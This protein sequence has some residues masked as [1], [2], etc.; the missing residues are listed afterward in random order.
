MT[1]M[2]VVIICLLNHYK[3][4]TWSFIARQSQA[5][6]H[7]HALQQVGHMHKHTHTPTYAQK[8]AFENGQMESAGQSRHTEDDSAE[9]QQSQSEKCV[10]CF[11]CL[12][13]MSVA[14]RQQLAARSLRGK[15]SS[16]SVYRRWPPEEA[17]LWRSRTLVLLDPLL[18]K[19]SCFHVWCNLKVKTRPFPEDSASLSVFLYSFT[20]VCVYFR[21]CTDFKLGRGDRLHPK[22]E[23]WSSFIP[24]SPWHLHNPTHLWQELLIK[25]GLSSRRRRVENLNISIHNKCKHWCV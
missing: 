3:F 19:P 17:P 12:E 13:R 1:V 22:L 16:W 18:L 4:S 23:R 9:R 5:R 24:L 10:L 6:R 20:W 25:F 2:V 11:Y 7:E 8:C 14:C 15:S 21:V